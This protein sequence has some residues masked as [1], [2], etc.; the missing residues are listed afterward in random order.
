M[1]NRDRVP[2]LPGSSPRPTNRGDGYGRAPAPQQQPPPRQPGY[3]TRMGGYE[4]N[5]AGGPGYGGPPGYGSGPGAQQRMPARGPPPGG[6]GGGG[7]GGG[8]SRP[9]LRLR[10]IK[11]P[12]GNAFAFGNLCDP[13]HIPRTANLMFPGLPSPLRTSHPTATVQTSTF[14]STATMYFLRGLPKAVGRVRSDSQM[15]K[16]RGRP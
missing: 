10:P 8:G 15:H 5:T 12:G 3:D 16:G 11:S 7:G 4:D 2:G 13:W 6:M 9:A 1:F 14:W